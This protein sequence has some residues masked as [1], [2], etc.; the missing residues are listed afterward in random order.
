MDEPER[1]ASALRRG[2]VWR[3]PTSAVNLAANDFRADG[4]SVASGAVALQPNSSIRV[5]A[6]RAGVR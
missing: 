5:A 4:I 2:L 6:A 1:L 3:R